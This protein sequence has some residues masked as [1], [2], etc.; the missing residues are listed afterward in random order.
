[1]TSA[2]LPLSQSDTGKAWLAQFPSPNDRGAAG[3]LLNAM[4]LLNETEVADAIRDAIDKS[5]RL[6]GPGPPSGSLRRARF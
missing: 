1:V 4:L 5:S 6:D 2:R 3:K